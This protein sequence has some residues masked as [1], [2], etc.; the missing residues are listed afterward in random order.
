MAPN[1]WPLRVRILLVTFK[2]GT[3]LLSVAL[4]NFLMTDLLQSPAAFMV[5]QYSEEK[6]TQFYFRVTVTL[7]NIH[8]RPFFR[9]YSM[10]TGAG[11]SS[12]FVFLFVFCFECCW[13]QQKDFGTSKTLP[14]FCQNLDSLQTTSPLETVGENSAKRKKQL[15]ELC[16]QQ[17]V[18]KS[19][20][21]YTTMHTSSLRATATLNR[22]WNHSGIGWFWASGTIPNKRG[23]S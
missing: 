21:G 6:K 20:T 15:L 14:P 1:H 9:P 12:V 16:M 8:H 13:F 23:F 3:Q 5:T 4:S 19:D 17:L 18:L 10:S 2:I 11:L 7:C 22:D